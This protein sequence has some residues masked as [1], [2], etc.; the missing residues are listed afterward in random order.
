[1]LFNGY[2]G[3]SYWYMAESERISQECWVK[4]DRHKKE[5]AV[6]VYIWSFR[7][8]KSHLIVYKLKFASGGWG[9]EGLG[10]DWEWARGNFLEW[11]QYSTL[12]R[13][14]IIYTDKIIGKEK[15]KLYSQITWSHLKNAYQ[16]CTYTYMHIYIY[17]CIYV[18]EVR[19]E[20]SSH[21]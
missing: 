12:I 16:N 17:I 21:C 11:W 20:K 14:V 4:E 7:E 8:G 18:Y 5:Y 3:T 19:P 15:V 6:W 2:K 9:R 13:V 1:M 10:F